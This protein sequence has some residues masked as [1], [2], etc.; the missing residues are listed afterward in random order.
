VAIF[1]TRE[2]SATVRKGSVI[3]LMMFEEPGV[4][5]TRKAVNALSR[6]LPQKPKLSIA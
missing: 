4:R 6:A 5:N 1:T 2:R 3:S